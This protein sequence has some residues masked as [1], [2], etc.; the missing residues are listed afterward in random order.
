M[1]MQERNWKPMTLCFK[2][3]KLSLS[4][5]RGVDIMRLQKRK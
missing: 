3:Q 5:D 4:I 1:Y 2:E